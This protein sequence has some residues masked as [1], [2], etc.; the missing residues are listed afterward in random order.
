MISSDL[1][2]PELCKGYTRMRQSPERIGIINSFDIK[3][4]VGC[5]SE[6]RAWDDTEVSE[7]EVMVDDGIIGRDREYRRENRFGKEKDSFKHISKLSCL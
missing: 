6:G 2:V 5:R 1:P 4:A 7:M 3:L